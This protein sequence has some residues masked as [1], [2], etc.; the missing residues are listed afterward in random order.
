MVVACRFYRLLLKLSVLICWKLIT[1]LLVPNS[2]V[3]FCQHKK[4]EGIV[5]SLTDFFNVSLMRLA[6]LRGSAWWCTVFHFLLLFLR[7]DVKNRHTKY[8]SSPVGHFL[9][10]TPPLIFWFI[11]TALELG[12]NV[13]R[14]FSLELLS[15]FSEVVA[16]GK[17]PALLTWAC[18]DIKLAVCLRK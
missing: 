9:S 10:L 1:G 18:R 4:Q 2:R 14:D 3:Y 7:A 17:T 16:G 6:G 5:R 11:S 8:S 13:Y 15:H 12:R